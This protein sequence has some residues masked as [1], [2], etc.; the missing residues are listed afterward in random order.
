M[1]NRAGRK[2]RLRRRP[3]VAR[4]FREG[5]RCCDA[6]IT[7]F[8][9]DNSLAHS[10]VAVGVSKRHGPAVRRNRIK[11]LCREAFRLVR[12]ELP[13]GL[14]YM[15]VPRAGGEF[16]LERL[17]ASL[18]QLAPKLAAGMTGQDEST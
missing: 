5:R 7:L 9:A 18:R 12:G 13:G 15:I 16:T 2:L 14:D 11:R 17:K 4:L 8:A 3:E 6:V 10:R 1:D